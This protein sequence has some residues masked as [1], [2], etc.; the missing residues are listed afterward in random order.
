[1]RHPL[2]VLKFGGSVL[3]CEKSLRIAVHDIYRWRRDGYRVLAVVSA[4]A[5]RTD[6]LLTQCDRV[7]D[8]AP[9]APDTRAHALARAA[10]IATGEIE[11]ASLL[12]LH[13]DRAGVPASTLLPHACDL[14]ARGDPLEATPTSLNTAPINNLL[15]SHAAVV[16]PGFIATDE[17]AQTV[18]LGRGGSDLTAL[19]LAHQLGAS[20]CRLIKDADGLYTADPARPGPCPPRYEQASYADALATDGSIVQHRAVR[21]AQSVNLSFELGRVNG[22]RPTRIAPAPS[23]LGAEPDLPRRRTVALLGLGTVGRGVLDLL[24]DL[25]DHFEIIGA[26]VRDPARHDDIDPSLLTT[27][28]IELASRGADIVV[29]ALG[30][31]EPARAAIRAALQSGAH[32]VTAN[33]AV[34]AEH[35]DE[36][37]SLTNTHNRT[38]LAS[39]SVGGALPAIERAAAAPVR[40]IRAVLNGTANFVLESIHAGNSLAEAIAQAQRLG[41]AEADPARDLD[42]RDSLDKLRVLARTLALPSTLPADAQHGAITENAI[43][44]APGSRLRQVATLDA[45]ALRIRLE[46]VEPTD[47]LYDLPAESN[48]IVIER[49]D[50]SMEILR[51]KGAGRWPTSESVL[52]DL[53]ELSRADTAL[54]AGTL[55][56]PHRRHARNHAQKGPLH[57]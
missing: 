45:T 3:A 41:L 19:F 28:P 13:L 8:R 46:S 7:S 17:S 20:L 57:V 48:A 39:A 15:E 22:T 29:E 1:M 35:A 25:P 36:L 34:L 2:I 9:S 21:F 47:P 10:H 54:A 18:T 32:V 27:D 33:K 37:E 6:A 51:A 52:A 43:A 12:A 4:L 38:L 11:A 30:G 26:A 44:G 5:G 16:V 23:V 40:S 24:Q 42:G 53:L 50:G 55:A 14:I 31:L 49:T 56:H